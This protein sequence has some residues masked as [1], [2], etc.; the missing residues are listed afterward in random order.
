MNFK[1]QIPP[2]LYEQIVQHIEQNCKTWQKGAFRRA[3]S[4][5][6]TLTG[7]FWVNLQLVN[8]LMRRMVGAGILNT[9]EL[10]DVEKVLLKN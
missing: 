1:D 4:D 9:I 10:G 7:D 6:D 8:N 5:E 2:E 3:Y